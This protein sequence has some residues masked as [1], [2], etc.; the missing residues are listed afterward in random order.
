V[1]GV[2]LRDA[3]VTDPAEVLFAEVAAKVTPSEPQRLRAA[4]T[5]RFGPL[6]GE[7]PLMARLFAELARVAPTDLSVCVEGETGT[8]KELV[9]QA[10]HAASRRKR[11]PLVVVDCAAISAQLVEAT[12]F[13]H[14]RGAFTGADRARRSPFLEANGGTVFLDEL[15]ELP[16]DAQPAL[17]RA[18]AER[19]VKPVGANAYLPFDA[20]VVAATRKDLAREINLG[21]FRS[22]LFFRVAQ[23]RVAVPPL[24]ER[25]EDIPGLVRIFG[26]ANGVPDAFRKI[27]PGSLPRLM[28]HDW[29]GNVRELKNAVASACALR[30][31]ETLDVAA[32]LF[33]ARPA[34]NASFAYHA[35]KKDALAHFERAYFAALLA[36]S[37]GNL[38][39]MARRA[40]L[41]R[42]HVRRYLLTHG[43]MAPR[44]PKRPPKD[45]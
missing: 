20:R 39:E 31:G 12:L 26:R 6:Y 1:L 30:E 18:L 27:A 19:R 2:R 4:V 35:A 8:G 34:A 40:G 13:G 7:S 14:E 11:G 29:P 45:R 44:P 33:D 21:A 15:G 38:A 25:V 42:T 10:I 36:T 23:V 3:L 16:L 37:D 28:R 17:L 22:D 43:L 32:H 24:R 5:E 9:A 41:Q